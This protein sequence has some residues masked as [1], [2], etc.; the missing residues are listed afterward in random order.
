MSRI[1]TALEQESDSPGMLRKFR[2]SPLSEQMEIK[3]PSLWDVQESIPASMAVRK[4]K[5][6]YHGGVPGYFVTV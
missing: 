5:P 1:C 2:T 6:R 3:Q 4:R